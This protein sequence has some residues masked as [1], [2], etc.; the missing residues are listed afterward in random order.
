MSTKYLGENPIE[1][2]NTPYAQYSN[3]DFAMLFNEKYG[4]IDGAHH[5]QWVLDQMVRILKG[6]EVLIMEARWKRKNGTILSE[7]RLETAKPPSEEYLKWRDAC[8]G[9]TY[10]DGSREYY[11]DEGIA[12]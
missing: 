6:T 2:F 9:K 10:A 7:Y 12:P 4:Q 8:R 1:Q 5:K 3:V 11:Y